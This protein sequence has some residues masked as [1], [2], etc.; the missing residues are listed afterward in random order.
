MGG[1]GV[2]CPFSHR[3]ISVFR[4][5]TERTGNPCAGARALIARASFSCPQ[6]RASRTARM[7]VADVMNRHSDNGFYLRR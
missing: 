1:S 3:D 5:A 2:M 7:G 6:P 4:L